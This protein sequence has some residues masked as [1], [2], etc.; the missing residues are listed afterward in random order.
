MAN[1]TIKVKVKIYPEKLRKIISNEDV[2]MR[3]IGREGVWSDKAIR[4]GLKTGVLTV[5]AVSYLAHYLGV[6]PE[7]FADI[8]R[9]FEEL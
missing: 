7:S 3:K 4:R 5:D 2:S 9:Y 6:N 1:K 8:D